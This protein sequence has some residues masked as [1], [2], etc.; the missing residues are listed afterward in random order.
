MTQEDL[1]C[2]RYLWKAAQA[3]S[4]EIFFFFFKTWL[5]KPG[6]SSH[7]PC[8]KQGEVEQSP[9]VVPSHPSGLMDP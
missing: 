3:P 2:Y 7:Q 1:Q 9:P 5:G 8:F 4:L 6:P